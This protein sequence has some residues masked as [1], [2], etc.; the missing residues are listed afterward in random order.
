[1]KI[2]I[3][4]G[5]IVNEDHVQDGDVVIEDGNILEVRGKI[6]TPHSDQRSEREEGGSETFDEVIDAGRYRHRE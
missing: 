1:M 3:K 4:G 6:A 5:H 2:L